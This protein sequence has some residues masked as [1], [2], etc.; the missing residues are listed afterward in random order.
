MRDGA[1][2]KNAYAD[3][4]QA[5]FYMSSL[6]KYDGPIN[7]I[8]LKKFPYPFSIVTDKDGIAWHLNGQVGKYI[9]AAKLNSVSEYWSSTNTIAAGFYEQTWLPHEV[10]ID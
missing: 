10:V 6:Q 7:K 2:S 4:R 3:W 8:H 9:L 1:R 5:M